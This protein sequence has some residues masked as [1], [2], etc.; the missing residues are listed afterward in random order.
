MEMITNRAD[1]NTAKNAGLITFEEVIYGDEI[2]TKVYIDED[3]HN[4]F[5][6][7][8]YSEVENEDGDVF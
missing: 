4:Y 5:E 3:G 2:M 6:Y 8:S 7:Y 1:Y